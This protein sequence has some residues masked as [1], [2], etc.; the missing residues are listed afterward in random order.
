[1]KK[2]Y[3]IFLANLTLR[4]ALGVI[5]GNIILGLGIAILRF[6]LM[7]NDPYTASTLAIS[8]G[9][10]VGLGNYQLALNIVLLIVQLIWGRKYLGFGTIINMCLLGYIVQFFSFVIDGVCEP[11]N[12]KSIVIKLLV[13]FLSFLVLTFGLSMYQVADLGVA[14]YDYLS[15]GMTESK[16]WKLPYFA[17]RVITDLGCVM[18]IVIAVFGGLIGWENSHLGIGTV[19]AAFCLGPFINFFNKYN[20][21]WIR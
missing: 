17:N 7:G 1:M 4:K 9:L 16:R 8:D 18:I 21:K 12:G 3:D 19:L 6:S 15:L 13:M 10:H 2:V 5:I 14:P 20:Q 11:L